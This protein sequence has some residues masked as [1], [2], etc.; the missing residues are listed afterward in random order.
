MV[1]RQVRAFAASS[2]CAVFYTPGWNDAWWW[3]KVL[4]ALC[5][6]TQG[7]SRSR[8]VYDPACRSFILCL[9]PPVRSPLPQ[10]LA[11]LQQSM[12]I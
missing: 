3:V 7:Q 1:N 6:T 12:R 9:Y 8:S 10:S 4:H 11:V 5:S 2:Q